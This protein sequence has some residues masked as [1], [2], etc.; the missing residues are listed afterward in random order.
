M[1]EFGLG[2]T[3]LFTPILYATGLLV[4]VLTVVY[5]IEI[6]IY[7]LAFFF[8]LQNILDYVNKYP[9]GSNIN[10]FLLLAMLVKWI[11]SKREPGQSFLTSTSLYLPI[12]LLVIWT[13]ME[14]FRGSAYL[15]YGNPTS[16]GNPLLMAWKNYWMPGIFFLIILNNIKSTKQIHLLFL[17]TLLAMLM[18]DR[19]FYTVLSQNEVEHYSDDLKEKLVSG[20]MALGGNTLA[21]FLAQN[22]VIFLA[23]F[24]SDT[25]RIRKMLFLFTAGLSYYC[26]MF[27]FSRG[28]YLAVVAS[29]FFLGV[30]KERKLLVLLV[31]L[32][33]FYNTLLPQAVIERIE[34]TK[35]ETGFDESAQ[36]RLGM[37]EQ[38]RAMISESPALGWGFSIT[39]FIEVKAGWQFGN[40]TW[41]SFHNNFIQTTVEIGFIGLALLMWIYFTG[42]WLG[43]KL[44]KLA[45]DPL[46]KGFGLGYCASVMGMLAGNLNG[47]YWHFYTVASYFWIYL[48][49][50][51]RLTIIATEAQAV[52]AAAKPQEMRI[53]VPDHLPEPA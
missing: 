18:L 28:G 8:P 26:I 48:A 16:M 23:L 42:M 15:G 3:G 51:I 39:P 50:V 5:R 37:W 30:I 6:G 46:Y 43:W 27:L 14:L 34:M 25:N 11:I 17:M 2:L 32:F 31:L 9:G 35:T 13:F 49:L 40:R 21:V 24:F 33:I 20:G 36:E 12:G 4:V 44:Y 7:F 22:A 29:L 38:A 10:D 41:G 45:D 19:N 1:F 52:T 47:S 53:A